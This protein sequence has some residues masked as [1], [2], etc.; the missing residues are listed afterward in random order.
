MIT[1]YPFT[2]RPSL[3]ADTLPD[4]EVVWVAFH[5]PTGKRAHGDTSDAALHALWKLLAP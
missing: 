3:W 4:G 2:F 1:V 5:K